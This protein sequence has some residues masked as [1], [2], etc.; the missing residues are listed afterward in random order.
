MTFT[1]KFFMPLLVM[2]CSMVIASCTNEAP[3]VDYTAK[4]SVEYAQV[5]YNWAAS[6][7]IKAI[8]PNQ[9]WGNWSIVEIDT[10]STRAA[11]PNSN[12]WSDFSIVPRDLSESERKLVMDFF[13]SIGAVEKKTSVN[14]SDFY[15][16]QVGNGNDATRNYMN[17][18]V[19][20]NSEN[21]IEHVNNFNASTPFN[22]K[23]LM[24]DCSTSWFGYHDSRHSKD[25]ELFICINGADIDK[26][27]DGKFFVGFD[28]E[29]DNKGNRDNIYND[30]VVCIS[31]CEYK[32]GT[33]VICEDMGVNGDFDFNDIV[34][35]VTSFAEWGNEKSYIITLRAVGGTLEAFIKDVEVHKAMNVATTTMA[36]TGLVSVPIAIFRIKGKFQTVKDIPIKVKDNVGEWILTCQ[37]A[38]PTQLISVSLNYKWCRENIS[39]IDAYPLFKDYVSEP[40]T[41]WEGNVVAEKVMNL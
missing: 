10:L 8:S 11:N 9:T 32:Q 4:K 1:K 12:Q 33:R 26:S 29:E 28:Y 20:A 2:V 38:H 5:W 16:Q 17:K 31:P 3:S 30:W 25:N 14:W 7:N 34:F 21:G 22:T 27:L 19:C 24:Q 15:V 36:N 18:L 6:N 40:S 39:I 23:M 35:D 13:G 41:Q 37:D